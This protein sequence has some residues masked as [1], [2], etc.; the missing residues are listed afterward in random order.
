MQR[1]CKNSGV[2]PFFMHRH[3]QR[4]GID[5]NC[6]LNVTINAKI[7][8]SGRIVGRAKSAND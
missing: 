7:P 4:G 1:C 6:H 3:P 2:L 5:R 8:Q